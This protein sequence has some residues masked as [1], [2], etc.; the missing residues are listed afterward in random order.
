MQNNIPRLTTEGLKLLMLPQA[1]YYWA[2]Q[3]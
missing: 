2:S 3:P 1:L